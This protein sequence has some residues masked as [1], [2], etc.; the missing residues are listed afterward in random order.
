MRDSSFINP[1]RLPFNFSGVSS[2]SQHEAG[3]STLLTTAQK[4]LVAVD[5]RR[6]AYFI[7]HDGTNVPPHS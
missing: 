2:W 7:L 6:C 5:Y 3:F 1:D 4:N